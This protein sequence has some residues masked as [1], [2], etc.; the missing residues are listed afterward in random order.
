[1]FQVHNKN[2]QDLPACRLT[3]QGILVQGEGIWQ[4]NGT[5]A[6][7]FT[8]GHG[9]GKTNPQGESMAQQGLSVQGEKIWQQN[10]KQS[11]GL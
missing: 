5:S 2:G 11:T 8:G 10:G 7:K 9:K 6:H 4:Q 3:Q 1:M